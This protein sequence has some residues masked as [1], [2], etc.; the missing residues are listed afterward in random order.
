MIGNLV[1]LILQ[2]TM[3]L[4]HNLPPG[5]THKDVEQRDEEEIS[6]DEQQSREEARAEYATRQQKRQFY[7]IKKIDELKPNWYVWEAEN[8][9]GVIGTIQASGD[10]E[11][12]A[13][14][15]WEAEE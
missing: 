13:I 7:L 8:A 4:N 12:I 1:A 3:N 6:Q 14:E 2:N 9:A 5:T 15:T 11:L 10:G